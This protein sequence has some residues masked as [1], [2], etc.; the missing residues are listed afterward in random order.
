MAR[1]R[2]IKDN[3]EPCRAAALSGEEFCLFHSPDR[4]EEVEEAR[5]LGGLRRRRERTVAR[6]YD[7][8]GL[9]SIDD[10]LRVLESTV[11]D[12]LSLDNSVDRSRALAQLCEIGR[13]CLA[14]DYEDK[15]RALEAALASRSLSQVDIPGLDLDVDIPCDSE[16]KGEAG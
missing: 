8:Q 13:R 2:L 16:K 9:R 1:C 11:S 15:I 7:Y 6:V 5:R 10:I 14:S 3:G 4:A 12:T